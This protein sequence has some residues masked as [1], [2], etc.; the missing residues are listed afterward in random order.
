M[1]TV[2]P[3]SR[4]PGL[5]LPERG[6][7]HNGQ[8]FNP[9]APSSLQDHLSERNLDLDQLSLQDQDQEDDDLDRQEVRITVL[10]T[11]LLFI[12]LNLYLTRQVS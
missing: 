2:L 5:P 7:S 12:L 9:P 4:S 8:Q 11:A 10:H 3:V 1:R 6:Q